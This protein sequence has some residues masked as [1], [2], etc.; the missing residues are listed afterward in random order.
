MQFM[1]LLQ[2]QAYGHMDNLI[3]TTLY[4]SVK[5]SKTSLSRYQATVINSLR[6]EELFIL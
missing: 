1:E 5:L 2:Y 6:K 4:G 3:Q